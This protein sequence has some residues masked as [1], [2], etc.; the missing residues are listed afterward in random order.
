[1]ELPNGPNNKEYGAL[2]IFYLIPTKPAD[3]QIKICS[4]FTGDIAGKILR[5]HGFEHIAKQLLPKIQQSL[6]GYL[7]V[8]ADGADGA[9]GADRFGVLVDH[10]DKTKSTI[11]KTKSKIPKITHIYAAVKPIFNIGN[12][13][14]SAPILINPPKDDP[15]FYHQHLDFM[16]TGFCEDEKIVEGG[17]N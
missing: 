17:F 3:Y 4:Q 1:M 7:V 6:F 8:D 12:I 11:S 10:I 2:G 16:T 14:E 5:K 13:V 9:D 15:A